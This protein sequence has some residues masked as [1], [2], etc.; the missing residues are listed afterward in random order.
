MHL[1]VRP[2]PIGPACKS[3]QIRV[4]HPEQVTREQVSGFDFQ[5][6][7]MSILADRISLLLGRR[8]SARN[9]IAVS[10]H[11]ETNDSSSTRRCRSLIRA[12]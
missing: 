8:E 6:Q 4:L 2:D 5:G 12:R 3:L 7:P 1:V 11:R 10:V 9:N